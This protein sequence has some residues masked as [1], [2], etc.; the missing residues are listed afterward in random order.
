MLAKHT[1][2]YCGNRLMY[3]N[4]PPGNVGF[5]ITASG[6]FFEALKGFYAGDYPTLTMSSDMS[7][8]FVGGVQQHLSDQDYEHFSEHL[9]AV[10]KCGL[11]KKRAPEG[12]VEDAELD[13][14][15]EKM[16][17]ELPTAKQ[18]LFAWRLNVELG[19]PA[20]PH[21]DTAE[22]LSPGQYYFNTKTHQEAWEKL[23][24]LRS[25]QGITSWSIGH[26]KAMATLP[27][28]R[29]NEYSE[30]LEDETTK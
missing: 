9:K 3:L 20:L 25:V 26:A 5:S 19:A 16:D 2:E 18:E 1:I 14:I 21:Y 29:S 23:Q 13:A 12:V 10:I 7:M 24:A 28:D 27:E 8:V 15:L 22:R 4:L 11:L 6:E 17:D 30:C